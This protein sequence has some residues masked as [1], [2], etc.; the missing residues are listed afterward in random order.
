MKKNVYLLGLILVFYN[1][2]QSNEGDNNS[3][4]L[5]SN[6]L[7]ELNEQKAFY[8]KKINDLNVELEKINNA[9][10]DL[11]VTEKRILITALKTKTSFFEHQIEVQA[12]IKTR[13][14]IMIY[15]EFNGRLIKL[16]VSE[17]QKVKK[18]RLLALIDDAGLKDQLEQ[19]KL[20]LDLAKTT[21]ERTERLWEQKIGSEMMYLEAKTRYKSAFK[22]VSQIKQ[23]LSRTKVYAPFDGIIDEIPARLGGN[24]VPGVTPILRIINLNSMYVESDV[25]ENYLPNIIKGSNLIIKLGINI[26]DNING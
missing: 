8:T 24:L 3:N 20:Q 16:N 15:P 23:Q 6:N 9:I 18:G 2:S 5:N 17:G 10:E 12:N 14:N 22:Q 25:P 13:K 19:S 26:L 21:F 4:P 1:C 7:K 11:A